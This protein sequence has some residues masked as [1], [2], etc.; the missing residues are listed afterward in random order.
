MAAPAPAVQEAGAGT[1]AS[2]FDVSISQNA[3]A[4]EFSVPQRIDVPSGGPRVTLTLGG[5]DAH[6]RLY[7]RT[8]PLQHP[9][10]WLVAEL[11]RPE[12]VWP[13]GALQLYRDGAYVGTDTLRT[14]E[15]GPLSLSFG[16]DELVT[17]RVVPPKEQR[18]SAGFASSRTERRVERAYT[19]E[20]RHRTPVE[21][22]VLE[23]SPVA[24][25]EDV[26]VETRFEPQP[27]SLAWKEQT[28]VVLWSQELAAG[29]S[30]R[31]SASYTLT[32]PKDAR[33][34]ESH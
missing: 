34:Q 27:K 11:P 25:H 31:F 30:A 14:G 10:A 32:W 24:T 12:G 9:S 33:L 19:V 3:F 17:V 5:H 16:R 13:V 8:S 23:A 7:S 18:G 26:K 29:Q 21:L 4:T 28:G 22:Q 6:A 15:E 20:N 2:S 1:T